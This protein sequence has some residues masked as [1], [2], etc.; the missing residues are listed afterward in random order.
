MLRPVLKRLKIKN[1]RYHGQY[2]QVPKLHFINI[3]EE[4]P[5]ELIVK[6]PE[7]QTPQP[8]MSRIDLLQYIKGN[9]ENNVGSWQNN[10]RISDLPSWYERLN[11]PS[12]YSLLNDK[13]LE[14]IPTLYRSFQRCYARV[15]ASFTDNYLSLPKSRMKELQA[16][17]SDQELPENI[18]QQLVKISVAT[19]KFSELSSNTYTLYQRLKINRLTPPFYL[20]QQFLIN[21]G[22]E[23]VERLLELYFELPEPRPLHL[24]REEFERFMRILLRL[25]I[26]KDHKLLLP[27][28][29]QLYEDIQINGRGIQLTSFETTK[30]FSFLLNLW[31]QQ[32][33]PLD[34]RFQRI[35][36]M[37]ERRGLNRLVFYPAMWNI[38]LSHFPFKIDEIM[39]LMANES[40]LTRSTASTFIKYLKSLDSLNNTLELMKLKRFHL[41]PYL[42]D[43]IIEKYTEFGKSKD[44]FQVVESVINKFENISEM[45]YVIPTKASHRIDI[46]RIDILNKTFQQ[47]HNYDPKLKFS[48]LKYKFKP[49][50]FTLGKLLI[51]LDTYNRYK[52]LKIML[53]HKIPLSNKHALKLIQQRHLNSLPYILRLVNESQA[54]NERLHQVIH[55]VRYDTKFLEQFVHDKNDRIV[56]T[57]E[58]FDLS[59]SIYKENQKT[60]NIDSIKSDIAAELIKFEKYKAM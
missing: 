13:S 36:K 17:L 25:K 35:L 58:I 10:L 1:N 40:G 49:S 4:T 21:L 6:R 26:S 60:D 57:N 2:I 3:K 59:I 56:E 34:E 7:V 48:W 30:Y 44:A 38:F 53:E 51:S 12:S 19:R 24:K 42:F 46:F 47:L 41:D 37:K 28:L 32:D 5:T 9:K 29:V 23:N 20:H 45:N 27:K 11:L 22:E 55:D 50:P 33:I 43:L 15:L 8:T 52:L 39:K 31:K 14:E 54:F 16:K 18:Q